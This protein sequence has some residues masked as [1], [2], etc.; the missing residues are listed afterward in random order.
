[1]DIVAKWAVNSP[2]VDFAEAVDVYV[3]R[4]EI[5]FVGVKAGTSVVVVAGKN[6]DLRL[7][8]ESLA[9][10]Q[11]YWGY[12]SRPIFVKTFHGKNATWLRLFGF[13]EN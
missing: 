11:K 1:M 10:N 8:Q 9:E 13:S 5:G 7:R 12:Q 6:V 3:C 4:R 2:V